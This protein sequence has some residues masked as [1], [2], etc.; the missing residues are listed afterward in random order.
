MNWFRTI[1]AAVAA[2]YVIDVPIRR[3]LAAK[4]ARAYARRKGKPLLNVGAGTGRTAL[5]GATLYGDVNVD[6]AGR[7]DVAHGTPGVVTYADA[8]DLSEFPDG[9]FGAVLA[10]H[11]LEHLPDPQRAMREWL[12]V[13]GG[14]RNAIFVVTPSWWAPHTWLHRGH[15]WYF[16]DGQGCIT[17]CEPRALNGIAGA[18][19]AGGLVLRPRHGHQRVPS[20]T[21]GA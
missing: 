14:D 18:T 21:R 8:Q 19:P 7:R 9:A 1:A 13:V 12:R 5:F 4:A 11:I 17:G 15:L 3:S 6:L 16:P 2:T 20:R 10:S